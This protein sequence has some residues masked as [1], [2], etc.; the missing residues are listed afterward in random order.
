MSLRGPGGEHHWEF[1]NFVQAEEAQAL[2]IEIVI[3]DTA[4]FIDIAEN[5]TLQLWKAMGKKRK[6]KKDLSVGLG[7]QRG[8]PLNSKPPHPTG[9][10]GMS[11]RPPHS[12]HHD[13][14]HKHSRSSI[15]RNLQAWPY[16]DREPIETDYTV[17]RRPPPCG[18][19]SNVVPLQ[20]H[21]PTDEVIPANLDLSQA[22][23]QSLPQ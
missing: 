16:V 9:W 15:C 17:P 3:L 14:I 4:C 20:H 12:T 2:E 6:N 19:F 13:A 10:I 23:S 22:A 11:T 7:H 21:S 5:I 18:I 8:S 1:W